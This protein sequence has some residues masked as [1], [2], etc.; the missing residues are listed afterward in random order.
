MLIIGVKCLLIRP[1]FSKVIL[2]RASGCRNIHCFDPA[3]ESGSKTE[4][5]RGTRRRDN[6]GV[7]GISTLT[8]LMLNIQ[9]YVQ[10][11]SRSQETRC[12]R[13]D[14]LHESLLFG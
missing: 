4:V 6:G 12:L 9:A 11:L 2:Q 14:S 5:L 13:D 7:S 1:C 8:G 3:L 10:P